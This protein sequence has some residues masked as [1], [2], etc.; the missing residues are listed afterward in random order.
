LA[1][2][3]LIKFANVNYENEPINWPTLAASQAAGA[4]WPRQRAIQAWLS[5]D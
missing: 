2:K 5:A 4:Q 3:N 1:N